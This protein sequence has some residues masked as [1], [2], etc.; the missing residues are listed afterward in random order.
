MDRAEVQ[1]V[2]LLSRLKLSDDEV[3]TFQDQL[4]R[5]LEYVTLLD[6]V[7]TDNVEPMAHAVEQSNI[8]RDDQITESLPSDAALSNAPKSDG[9]F[10]LVPPILNAE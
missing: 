3:T 10:F 2:A 1:K 8:L 7:D 9:E 5:I 6:E 4:G